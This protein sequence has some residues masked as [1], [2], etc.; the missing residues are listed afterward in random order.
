[1]NAPRAG[2]KFLSNFTT[3]MN[4]LICKVGIYALGNVTVKLERGPA[5]ILIK[6]VQAEVCEF[7]GNHLLGQVTTQ[8]VLELAEERFNTGTELGVMKL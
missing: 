5:I 4:C 1:M 3:P 7:C 6:N 8:K 2:D